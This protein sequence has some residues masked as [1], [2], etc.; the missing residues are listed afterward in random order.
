VTTSGSD[1]VLV[2]SIVALVL[3][4]AGAV[5]SICPGRA[6]PGSGLATFELVETRRP[7]CPGEAPLPPTPTLGDSAA[8]TAAK[9]S[10]NPAPCC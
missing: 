9:L 5:R 7:V 3:V 2:T 6:P 10:S 8:F 4:P 1:P